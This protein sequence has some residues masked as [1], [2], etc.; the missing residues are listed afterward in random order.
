V[1]LIRLALPVAAVVGVLLAPAAQAATKPAYAG[2]P[3]KGALKGVPPTTVDN[4][5][6]PSTIKVHV[7]D[8]IAFKFLGFHNVLFPPKGKPAPSFALLDPSK[9]V[10]GAKDAAGADMWFNGQPSVA[11]NP[12]VAAP[13]GSKVI[14]GKGT[15]GSG[16]PAGKPKDYKVKFSKT[17]TFTY[18]CSIH[19]GMKGTVKVLK[20]SATV[21][22]K[23]ADAKTISKQV[24]TA[25]KLAKQLVGQAPPAG[26]VVNAG[27]DKKGIASLAF[28]PATK[29]IHAGESVTFQLP[30]SSTESHNVAVGPEPYVLGQTLEGPGGTLNP[31]VVYPSD[32][33]GPLPPLTPTTHGNGYLS[34]GMMDT[35]SATPFPNKQSI[36]FTT[37][38][39]YVYY[40]NLHEPDMK[41][42][43]VVQ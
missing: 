42:T 1:R 2:T 33:P 12:V 40:C 9:P 4:A 35:Q 24:A 14:D 11:F 41:G 6:Y 27:Q 8:S 32:P 13:S 31:F 18:Y 36:T 34:T 30:G 28:F 7:G 15:H 16:L 29:T 23:A 17:G 38:G 10:S 5:F 20:K 26:N 21:Q 43:I 39:T 37:P 25:T 22:S 3:P 19:P